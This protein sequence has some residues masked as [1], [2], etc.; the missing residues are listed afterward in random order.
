MSSHF[1]FPNICFIPYYFSINVLTKSALF[2]LDTR[3]HVEQFQSFA[4]NGMPRTHH[5]TWT[6]NRRNKTSPSVSTFVHLRIHLRSH[7]IQKKRKKKCWQRHIS[8]FDRRSNCGSFFSNLRLRDDGKT[9]LLQNNTLLFEF[10]IN[11]WQFLFEFHR[12]IKILRATEA[13]VFY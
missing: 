2:C 12:L 13:V 8:R 3:S 9:R 11:R 5:D 6:I 1:N 7:V 4:D 10:L